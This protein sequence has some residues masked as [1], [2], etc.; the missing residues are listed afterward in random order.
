MNR[1]SFRSLWAVFTVCLVGLAATPG[2]RAGMIILSGDINIFDGLPGGQNPTAGN[3]TFFSNVLGGGTSVLIENGYS[4]N[5]HTLLN[6]FYNSLG[7]VNSA[8]LGAPISGAALSGVNL[9]V[10][11]LPSASY[12]AGEIAALSTF[13]SGG[14]TVMFVGE[15]SNFPNENARINAALGSLGSGMSLN[16]TLF[17]PG[18]QI[19]TGAQIAA[20]ALTAGINSFTYAA[21]SEVTVNG[22][23]ALFFGQGGQPFV[24]VDGQNRVPDTGATIPLFGLIMGLLAWCA[25][26]M[27]VAA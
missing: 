17:E 10:T 23:T 13:L 18:F 6:N 12:D 3:S 15:N 22:G 27:N 24:A 19:A 4:S 14:G 11:M 9:F 8:I 2:L 20:H 16:N 5:Q 21:P 26:R 7:G 1:H 25:R